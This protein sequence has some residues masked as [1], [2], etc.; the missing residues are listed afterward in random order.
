[1]IV[2]VAIRQDGST[3]TLP[4]PARHHQV[5]YD[6]VVLFGL[7]PP[8]KGEQGFITDEGTFV[9]R[10]TAKDIARSHGQLLP[11][12]SHLPELF[13]EDVW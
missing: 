4:R 8:I 1:M 11:R 10:V 9:D 2:A 13:S 3:F 6:M 12:A 7:T 5:I